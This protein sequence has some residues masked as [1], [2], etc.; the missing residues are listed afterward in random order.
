MV[1]K[2]INVL[3]EEYIN[4]FG[5]ELDKSSGAPIP[6]AIST[7]ANRVENSEHALRYLMCAMLPSL[8]NADGP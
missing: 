2:I 1:T 7:R 4:P 3:K 6:D 5:T 8:T